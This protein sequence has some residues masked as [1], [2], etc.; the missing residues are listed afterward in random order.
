MFIGEYTNTLDSKNRLSVPAK[1]R[2]DLGDKA[3]LAYGLNKALALYPEAEWE[4]YAEKLAG[5]SMGNPAE[6]QYARTILAGAFEVEIDK[7]GRI[8]VPPQQ[9]DFAGIKSKVVFTG[10]FKYA[11]LWD[12]DTWKEY[13]GKAVADTDKLAEMLGEKI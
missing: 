12:E 1:F 11:E 13:Q 5:L 8:V 4:K 10:M 6:R 2:K 7:V 3:V 9:K